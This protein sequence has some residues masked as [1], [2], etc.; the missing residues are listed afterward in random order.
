M[1]T[2]PKAPT[3]TMRHADDEHDE[4]VELTRE[5]LDMFTMI[6]EEH[7]EDAWD[8]VAFTWDDMT[9]DEAVRRLGKPIRP[10]GRRGEDLLNAILELSGA[11]VHIE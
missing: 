2:T 6:P 9:L 11:E 10:V 7:T 4:D 8:D 3:R 1:H 5:A